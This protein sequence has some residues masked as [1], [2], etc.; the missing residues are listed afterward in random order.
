MTTCLR[1]CFV[2]HRAAPFPGGTE[3]FVQA[4]AEE[5]LSHGHDVTILTG[6]HQGDLNGVRITA[7]QTLLDRERFDLVVVHGSNDGAPRNTLDRAASLPSPVLYMLGAHRLGHVSPHHLWAATVLGWSTPLDCAIIAR[8]GLANREVRVRHG[9]RLDGS[10]GGPGFREKWG[11]APDRRLFLSCGG[12]APHKRMLPLARTFEAANTNGLLVTTGYDKR[13]GDM[14]RRS[15]KVLPLLID[16]HAEVLSAIAEADCYLMHS[17]EEGFGLVLLEAMLNSTPWIA[18][19]TGGATVL[20]DLGQTYVRDADLVQ[21]IEGFSPDPNQIARA[22]ATVTAEYG[23][24]NTLADLVAAAEKAAAGPAAPLQ[25]SSLL[26][27]WHRIRS[28]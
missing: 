5:A 20:A 9:I 25:P 7:D 14:P 26:Q 2:S 10:V 8:H 18:H 4:M 6:Q 16:D 3:V 24:A 11:I 13:P 17:R 21:L 22:K 27:L 12:Y 19:A 1:F 15:H 28:L 23:M